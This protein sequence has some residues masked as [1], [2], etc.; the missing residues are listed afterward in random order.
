MEGACQG[1]W[2]AAVMVRQDIPRGSAK[3]SSRFVAFVP[4][5]HR[6]GSLLQTPPRLSQKSVH[7][8]LASA[9]KNWG[10]CLLQGQNR[11]SAIEGSPSQE[12]ELSAGWYE[13][14][15]FRTAGAPSLPGNARSTST[16]REIPFPAKVAFSSKDRVSVGQYPPMQCWL[17]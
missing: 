1:L 17:S 12:F 6:P 7:D 14:C 3:A 4:V 2:I 10:F 13:H 5:G 11:L 9:S 15:P 8:M 16:Q